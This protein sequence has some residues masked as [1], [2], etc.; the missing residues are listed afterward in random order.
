MKRYQQIIGLFFVGFI[1]LIIAAW[2]LYKS[3][4]NN[5][6]QSDEIVEAQWAQVENKL[7][8]RYDTIPNLVATVKGVSD[9]E[10]EVIKNI[11]DAR[12]N[13]QN[14]KGVQDTEQAIGALEQNINTLISVVHENYPE[15][16]STEAYLTLMTQLEGTENRISVERGKYNDAV[17]RYNRQIKS[18]PGNI[19]AKQFGFEAKPYFKADEKAQTVP[20]VS[21]GDKEE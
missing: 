14:A 13:Y 7:Q 1:L 16:A 17:S 8:R 4:Y 3:T 2:G 18:F 9:H 10:K 11:T 20:N 6:V 5:F 15:I 21:F 19:I 12:T